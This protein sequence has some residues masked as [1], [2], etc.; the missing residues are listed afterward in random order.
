MTELRR[1]QHAAALSLPLALLACGGDP[2]PPPQAPSPPVATAAPVAA[3]P[4]AFA[5]DDYEHVFLDRDRRTKLASAFPAIDRMVDAHVSDKKLPGTVVGV[6]VDGDLVHTAASGVADVDTRAK[7]DADT[8]YRIGSITKSFTALALLALRDEGALALDEPLARFIPEASGVVYP[9]RDTPP[10]TLRQ[11]L[12][13]RSGLSRMGKYIALGEDHAT[14]EEELLQSLPGAVLESAPGT[15]FSYS[16]FGYSLLGVVVARAAH[17]PLRDVVAARLLA[18]LGMTSTAW[19]TSTLPAARVATPYKRRADGAVELA[20]TPN[21]ASTEGSGGLYS[22]VRDMA[23]YAA[24]QLSAY[25]PRSD[26]DTGPVRRSTLREAHGSALRSSPLRVTVRDDAAPGDSAVKASSYAYGYAWGVGES[27]DID[28]MVGH[29]G[30]IGGYASTLQTLPD[31]GVAVISL[32]NV[33]DDRSVSD[34]DRLAIDV[35][36]LLHKTGG[37]TKRTRRMKQ[38][39]AAF[40]AVM[41]RFLAVLN[42]WDE[43]GYRAM[44]T[45]G[46]KVPSEK[47]EMAGYH[48][49]HG[50]CKGYAAT[51]I[52]SPT[53]ARFALTCERGALEMNVQLGA[54]DG[55]VAGFSGT[56]RNVP[57]PP[58]IAKVGGL[59][60]GLIG[61]WSAPV[62]KRH[63]APRSKKPEAET[64]TFFER[65]RATHG[66]CKVTSFSSRG[67]KPELALTCERGGN[68]ALSL[69]LDEKEDG[70]VSR[71]TITPLDPG[72]CP[73]K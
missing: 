33:F 65:I 57:A 2:P 53:H 13:H 25:P 29:N 22:S 58:R 44:L 15:E 35:I 71:Y 46:R 32:V 70:V 45:K 7:A 43:E 34:N 67:N 5:P 21:L 55:L 14:T 24:F 50:D 42:R 61:K 64:A 6:V 52:L 40:D 56:S 36:R 68:L 49:T 47:D 8:I 1:L 3:P 19:D 30:A 69:E 38:L 23:R 12:G 60:A 27:C 63:L 59:L 73:I 10:I 66:A 20:R 16:N 54:A 18:P 41:P 9:T 26:A 11:L 28:R 17:K 39:P 4:Q 31:R 72:A 37:L 48:A 51:E 62:Y